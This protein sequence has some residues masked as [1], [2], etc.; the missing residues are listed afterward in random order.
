MN[1][2]SARLETRLIHAGEGRV[3]GAVSLPVFQSSVFAI[4][5]EAG[6]EGLKYPRYNNLPNQEA[7]A[8]KLASL[9][10]GEA[11]LVAA[12]GM[13]AITTA[14]LTVLGQGG[15]LLAVSPL[16]GGTQSLLARRFASWG[17]A[18]DLV[19][20]DDPAAWRANLRPETRALYV[21]AIT[22]PGVQVPD[23]EAVV[24]LARERGLVTLIDSTFATP[25]NFRPLEHGF[26]LA[27]HSCTKYLNGHSDL[28]AGAVVGRAGLIAE[29]EATQRILGGCLDPHACSLLQRG[30]KTLALRVRQQNDN[31]LALARFLEAHPAVARV[32]YPGLASHPAHA[33]ARRLFAGCGG[34][35]AFEPRGGAAAADRFLASVEVATHAPSLGG[36][37]TLVISPARSSHAGLSPAE[38]ARQGISDALVR[39]SV[40]IEHADDLCADFD[41]ALRA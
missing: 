32:A 29:I 39:V 5:D 1:D 34:M 24:A 35:L 4:A 16:Y 31:A 12:S 2:T 33:R 11:A 3:E 30:M 21:E 13:A 9:E 25:I 7:V 37:E 40:G 23:L 10:G 41:Q 22:N 28:V 26:D 38:R 18:Y 27:L 19:L 20:D 15:H 36:I 17:L 6:Y 8:A 14:L